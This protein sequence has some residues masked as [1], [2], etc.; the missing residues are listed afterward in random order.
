[1]YILH[2]ILK[3]IIIFFY[4]FID[5]VNAKIKSEACAP[6]F[7]SLKVNEANAHI[8]PGYNYKNKVKYQQKGLPLIITAKYDVWRKVLDMN[9]E[10]GWLKQSQL[11]NKRYLMVKSEKCILFEKN[12][13]HSKQIAILKK[14]VVME[15]KEINNNWCKVNVIVNKK[16]KCGGYVQR[17]NIYGLLENEF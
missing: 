12:D 16:K 11:S 9:N 2:N 15:L 8:G 13:I 17:E 10:E 1:M 7:V 6:Y 14:Q 4:V 5:N 3:S